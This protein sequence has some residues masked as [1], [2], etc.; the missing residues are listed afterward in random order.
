MKQ[1]VVLATWVI[2][3]K[4]C[5]SR[6]R[7]TFLPCLRTKEGECK[8]RS[9]QHNTHARTTTLSHDGEAYSMGRVFTHLLQLKGFCLD[10]LH[11]CFACWTKPLGTS[12]PL[13]TLTD[14]GR[15]KSELIA[16]NALLRQQLIMLRRQVK[17]P[18]FT[19][20]DRILLVLLARLVRTWQR[21][22]VIVQPETLLRW[23][24]ELF[25]LYWKRKS[26]T[27]T[28][29]PKVAA[30]TIA[31]IREMARNN[32]LWGAEGIRGELLK[33]GIRGC[34]T[35]LFSLVHENHSSALS[36]VESQLTARKRRA[37]KAQM[38][39]SRTDAL[40]S[41]YRS[42]DGN[43]LLLCSS[44]AITKRGDAG[45]DGS[46]EAVPRSRVSPGG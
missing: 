2:R 39:L 37:L 8:I 20:I 27:H 38:T 7:M 17:R 26:K 30:E 43:T 5:P 36:R 31:L 9:R 45:G 11:S 46:W 33:L 13:A 21:A 25:R 16:E 40:S 32:R 29:Q 42:Y 4:T 24:R 23:H 19:R 22:L 35:C 18:T 14:L 12:L 10:M 41:Q 3:S 6:M 15:S 28:H 44:K 34:H 1:E